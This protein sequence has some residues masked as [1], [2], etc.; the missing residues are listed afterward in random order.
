MPATRCDH[1]RG[2]FQEGINEN[3]IT[4]TSVSDIP[5][6]KII[7]QCE[8]TFNTLDV[9]IKLRLKYRENAHVKYT[10]V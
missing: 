2:H 10:V 3:K 1:L 9:V 6:W 7:V 8:Y 4:T 5:P